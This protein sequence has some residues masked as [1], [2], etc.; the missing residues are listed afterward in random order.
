[1]IKICILDYG[2]GNVRSVFNVIKHLGYDVEISN[3]KLAIKNSSHLILPGV[4]SY[5]S[6]MDKINEKIPLECLEN[7]VFI[8]GKPFLGI[9]VGMQVL[10]DEGNEFGKKEGLGWINGS[11]NI[12]DSDN[13]PLP[14]VGWNDVDFKVEK[15]IMNGLLDNK[16]FYFVHSYYF[17]ALKKEN[18][19]ATT[20]YGK[21]FPSIVNKD[22]IYG[23]QFHPEK[24]QRAGQ[25]ILKNFI[26]L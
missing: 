20:S 19:I 24:S 4:G 15:S 5:G 2:S 3:S 18:V 16:D 1:M 26:K 6:A 17:E 12:L 22:N 13:L 14:H 7:S 25:L 21:N 23:F 9:C 10:S 11:V 8:D